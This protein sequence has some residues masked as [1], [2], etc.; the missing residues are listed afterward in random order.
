PSTRA[1]VRRCPVM[2][3][4]RAIQASSMAVSFS[5]DTLQL[6]NLFVTDG[7]YGRHRTTSTLCLSKRQPKNQRGRRTAGLFVIARAPSRRLETGMTIKLV[8]GFVT[9]IDFQEHLP[10]AARGESAEMAREQPVAEAAPLC[11]RR[12][13]HH[14]NLRLVHR[15]AR[16]CECK[17]LTRPA[18]CARN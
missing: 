15:H 17:H 5:S 18:A 7:F 16:D 2:R 9:F 11:A 13:R 4:P 6:A 1:I 8:C 12:D 10:C 3:I 14:E